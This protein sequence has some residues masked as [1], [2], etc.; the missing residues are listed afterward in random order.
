MKTKNGQISILVLVIAAISLT[1]GLSL[2]K[3]SVNEIQVDTNT[4][5]SKKA[6]SV[7]ESA[8]NKFYGGNRQPLSDTNISGGTASVAESSI[9]GIS[10]KLDFPQFV[11]NNDMAFF[12]LMGHNSDGTLNYSDTFSDTSVIVC[13]NQSF[14]GAVAIETYYRDNSPTPQ[15]LVKRTGFNTKDP[16]IVMG[17]GVTG[18]TVANTSNT[19]EDNMAQVRDGGGNNLSLVSGQANFKP[20]FLVVRPINPADSIK[21]TKIRLVSIGANFPSQGNQILS[22]GK[23]GQTQR[24]IRVNNLYSLA[25]PY[26]FML[27]AIT[28]G[29]SIKS[30]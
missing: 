2:S 5:E 1:F 10:N 11:A 13:V 18:F 27:Q 8:L 22:T 16:A 17:V 29:G 20:V 19:C 4:E 30:N 6:F 7:A 14:D 15:F 25:L 21:G 23:F 26:N 24:T 12:W 28:A 3:R 9:V